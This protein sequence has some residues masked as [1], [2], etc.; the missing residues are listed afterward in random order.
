MALGDALAV[1]VLQ[2]RGFK[3]DDFKAFHPGGNLGAVLTRVDDIMAS[4]DALPLVQKGEAFVKALEVMTDKGFG[5][6]GVTDERGHLIGMLTDG[7]IRRLVVSAKGSKF[8]DD[9]MVES[10]IVLTDNV[11]AS[12]ALGLFQTHKIS[13]VFRL[14]E[15]KHPIGLVHM[16]MLLKIGLL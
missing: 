9:A 15:Q 4:G 10:N 16:Q 8:I 2:S 5:C 11:L 7:D 14:N 12:E 13:Q 6:L 1:S 3:A